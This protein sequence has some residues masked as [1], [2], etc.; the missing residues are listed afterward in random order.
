MERKF[1][2]TISLHIAFIAWKEEAI[3]KAASDFSLISIK[4]LKYY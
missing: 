1:T 3:L 4:A 2:G